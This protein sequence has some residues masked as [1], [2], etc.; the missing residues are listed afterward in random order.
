MATERGRDAPWAAAG[1]RAK[2]MYRRDLVSFST[3]GT[4][5]TMA[6]EDAQGA[7]HVQYEV[8]TKAQEHL[9]AGGVLSDWPITGSIVSGV[10]QRLAPFKFFIVSIEPTVV[11]MLPHEFEDPIG[12]STSEILG[13][14]LEKGLFSKYLMNKGHH[15]VVCPYAEEFMWFSPDLDIGPTSISV[16]LHEA[17]TITVGNDQLVFK[18]IDDSMQIDRVT[19]VSTGSDLE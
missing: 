11:V 9:I 12:R 18:R 7:K 15:G 14:D 19:G 16:K 10:E 6:W 2:E 13:R 17:A 3:A 5:G 4:T 1:V 8:W